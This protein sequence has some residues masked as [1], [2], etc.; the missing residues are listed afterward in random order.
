LSGSLAA[1]YGL[2]LF[3]FSAAG[4]VVIVWLIGIYAL[5]IGI[6]LLLLALRLRRSKN[7]FVRL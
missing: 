2:L 3:V 5:I 1:L 4:S 7:M 6:L